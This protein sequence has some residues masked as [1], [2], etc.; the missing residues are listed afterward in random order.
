MLAMSWGQEHLGP[1]MIN[2]ALCIAVEHN[3]WLVLLAVF[4][5]CCGAF[6]IVHMFERA[7]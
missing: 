4:I 6:A 2:V 7:Q 3:P 1:S 5:C